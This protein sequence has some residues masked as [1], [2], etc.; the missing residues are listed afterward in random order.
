MRS[1]SLTRSTSISKPSRDRLVV[2]DL[3]K[4]LKDLAKAELDIIEGERRITEQIIRIEAM[5][6][7]GKDTTRA[8]EMLRTLEETLEAWRAHR[9]VILDAIARLE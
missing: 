7:A 5:R 9:Q 3:Q 6:N 2:P 1:G 4:E 8:E